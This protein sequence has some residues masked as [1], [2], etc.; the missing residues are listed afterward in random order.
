MWLAPWPGTPCC[1]MRWEMFLRKL[2][3]EA[4][5]VVLGETVSRLAAHCWASAALAASRESVTI[6]LVLV[7]FLETHH[8]QM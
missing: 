6:S 8:L 5:N 7:S 2:A 1:R 3:V 4:T